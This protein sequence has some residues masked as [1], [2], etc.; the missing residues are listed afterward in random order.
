[1]ATQRTLKL[2]LLADVDKFGKGLAKAGRDAQGFSGKVKAYGKVAA[3]AFAAVG[4][5]AGVMAVKLGLDAVRAASDLS[6]ELS[7]SQVIFGDTAKDIEKFGEQA[8]KSLGL[9]KKQAISAASTFATFGKAAGLTGKDLSKFSK[10]ATTLAADLGSFYNT[11][12]DEAILAIGA[13]LRG[14]SE[15]IRKYGVLLNQVTIEAKAVEMGLYDGT[16][17]LDAQAKS[18]AT[19]QVILDQTTDAQGDFARTSDGLAGQQKILDASIANLK[20]TF[21]ETLLPIMVDV[22]NFINDKMLPVMKN[23]AD[24]FAGKPNSISNKV[25][26]LAN[27]MGYGNQNAAYT[28]GGSLRDV[29]EALGQL[30]K[31]MVTPNADSGLSTMEN[32]ANSLESI[33]NGLESI[34]RNW[35]KVKGFWNI[36]TT[37]PLSYVFPG[38]NPAQR[39]NAL[40]GTVRAGV[41]TRVGEMG[42]EVFIPTSG[43]QIIPNNRLG[44]GGNTFIFNGVVD[45]ESARRSIER[46]MQQSTRRTGAVNLAGSQL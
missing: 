21:G 31:A 11:N 43:G 13:A 40:G 14:E 18:L 32:L 46:I 1:M 20:T 29:A 23:I 19:Y 26:A 27:E 6:E 8:D 4:V 16:G 39:G 12:A 38:A 42:S 37:S 35:G 25:Q 34:A 2:N 5:A 9:S 24:G 22:V 28:L 41:P 7:K 15:P 30:F 45:G 3:G 10:S 36:L 44:G 33:A 17:A